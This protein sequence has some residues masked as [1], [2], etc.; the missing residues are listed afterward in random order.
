MLRVT[1]SSAEVS[2]AAKFSPWPMPSSS[3]A[4]MRA[5]TMRAGSA[6]AMTAMA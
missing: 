3:G 2:E 1:C 4:P 5:T 6:A